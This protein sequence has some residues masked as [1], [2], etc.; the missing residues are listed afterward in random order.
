MPF[1]LQ[2]VADEYDADDHN[3]GGKVYRQEAGFGL[4]T[5]AD[6]GVDCAGK[7]MDPVTGD[8]GENGCDD[9]GEVE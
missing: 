3:R 9:G 8:F 6:T 1:T 2:S 4:E 5:A 7:V